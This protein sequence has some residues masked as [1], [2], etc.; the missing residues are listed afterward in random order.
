MDVGDATSMDVVE[1]GIEKQVG[2]ELGGSDSL[3]RSISPLSSRLEDGEVVT[4]ES[5]S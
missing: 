1:V 5:D 4:I 3:V 2:L